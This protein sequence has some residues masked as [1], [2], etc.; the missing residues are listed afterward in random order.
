MNILKMKITGYD[1]IS[2][3]LLVSFASDETKSQDPS[4]YTS[5]AY[6]PMTMWPEITDPAEIQKRIAVS[7]IHLVEQQKIKEDFLANEL[8]ANVYKNMV[9]QVVE[10]NKNDLIPAAPVPEDALTEIQV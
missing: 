4:D 7:G 9:G 10:F 5:F 6:Q 2:N 1:E 3:S 8:N